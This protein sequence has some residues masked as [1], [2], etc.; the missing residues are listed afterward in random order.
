MPGTF[1]PGIREFL[2]KYSG[3]A[4]RPT[5][6]G[7]ALT[8]SGIFDFAAEDDENNE[9]TDSYR[10]Q[11]LVPPSFPRALPEV[12]ET[13]DKIPR[14]GD[15]HINANGTLC[16][17]SRLRLLYQISSKPTLIGFAESCLTPYLYAISYKLKFGGDLLF[18]ELPHGTQGELLD[19]VNLFGLDK[20]EQAKAAISLLTMK[21]R[22]ANKF[23]CPCGCG[24]RLGKCSFNDKLRSYRD[25]ADRSWFK[26]LE[27]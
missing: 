17:G 8:L 10:L 15:Y 11:I 22:H 27:S 5:Q 14:T 18:S 24:R 13:E 9:I 6:E 16:L 7:S 12:K 19:Y 1:P 3:M 21:K 20:P 26:T 23:P 4:I 2:F 25:L